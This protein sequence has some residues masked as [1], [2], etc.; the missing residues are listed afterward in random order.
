M[1]AWRKPL[2]VAPHISRTLKNRQGFLMASRDNAAIVEEL[3]LRSQSRFDNVMQLLE[4]LDG[5]GG[6]TLLPGSVCVVTREYRRARGNRSSISHHFSPLLRKSTLFRS[7][8]RTR[9]CA[10]VR[11]VSKNRVRARIALDRGAQP[12]DSGP[13]ALSCWPPAAACDAS[14]LGIRIN[15]LGVGRHSD[16]AASDSGVGG[17]EVGALTRFSRIL[18]PPLLTRSF[19]RARMICDFGN[20]MKKYQYHCKSIYK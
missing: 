9:S 20:F 1:A 15:P 17:H 7:P 8:P 2:P 3:R 18:K 14:A 13:F 6:E 19:S 4:Q 5:D 10:T 16:P 11:V 12:N